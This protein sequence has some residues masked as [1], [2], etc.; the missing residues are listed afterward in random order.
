MM[1]HDAYDPFPIDE[2]DNFVRFDNVG[3]MLVG[4]TDIFGIVAS[5]DIV[6]IAVVVLVL[7][8]GFVARV[9]IVII[10]ATTSATTTTTTT[11]APMK[12]LRCTPAQC[13]FCSDGTT[14]FPR[15]KSLLLH[16]YCIPR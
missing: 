4:S 12:V 9:G 5:F 3:V 15:G 2:F 13:P 1:I 8:F 16:D 6:V 11:I 10:I 14:S 7:V